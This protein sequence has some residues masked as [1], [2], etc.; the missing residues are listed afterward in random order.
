MLSDLPD[1]HD[2]PHLRAALAF[3]TK[4]NPVPRI[5][6][7][8]GAHRGIWTR[9][10][11]HAFQQVLAFEPQADNFKALDR[12]RDSFT[13]LQ[14]FNTALG[15]RRGFGH[16][17]PGP[18]NTGQFHLTDDPEAPAVNI[19]PLDSLDL[20]NVDFLKLDVEGFELFALQGA[21]RTIDRCR[22]VVLIEENGLCQRYGVKDGQAGGWLMARGYKLALRCNK[23][24]IY[25]PPSRVTICASPVPENSHG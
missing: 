13:A 25:T 3:V 7:D 17:R 22:P 21:A 14:C 1:D 5:A 2:V 15:E 19:L 8:G 18:E 20:K 16:L 24:F 12:L 4:R 23:D 11:C 10:L 9:V 6:V